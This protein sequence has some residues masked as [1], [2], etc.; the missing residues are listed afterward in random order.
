MSA[1]YFIDRND[2]EEELAAAANE[3]YGMNVTASDIIVVPEIVMPQ[4]VYAGSLYIGTL[5]GSSFETDRQV[6]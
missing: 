1:P 5:T 4:A 6:S 2:L 3:A